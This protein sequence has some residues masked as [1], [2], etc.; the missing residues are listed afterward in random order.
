MKKFRPVVAVNYKLRVLLGKLARSQPVE[1]NKAPLVICSVFKNEAVYLKEWLDFHVSQGVKKFYLYNNF[2][3]DN[4]KEVL[5]PYIK[6]GLVVLKNTAS[7]GMSVSI[8]SK[9][10]NRG[11]DHIKKE[12]GAHCWVAFLDIDE[13]LFGL[14]KIDVPRILSGFT[15]KK[16]G[17]VVVNWL[18]FGTS[19]VK[20]LSKQKTMIE[21]LV[22]RAPK[23]HVGSTIF[24]PIVYLA[25]VSCFFR[26]PHLPVVKRGAKFY[27]SDKTP[28]P[29]KQRKCVH[30]PLRIN[31]Y[32]YRSEE[33]YKTEKKIK[34]A[35]F[36]YNRSARVEAHDIKESNKIL[37]RTILQ[38]IEQ[39]DSK[40]T[41]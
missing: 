14:D 1:S 9:E 39:T 22:Y 16:V 25:N 10:F 12:L 8:Q 34:R 19:N 36:G 38:S 15:G 32:W 26:G 18:M 24:K 35:A 31:H 27:Y 2:S 21:Q 29:I 3:S 6:Q 28:L 41:K 11:I 20:E 37:D 33:Y 17:A 40:A 4:F 30:E 7:K 5:N 23:E 13:Y